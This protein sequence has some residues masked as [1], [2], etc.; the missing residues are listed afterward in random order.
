MCC[1]KLRMPGTMRCIGR[2]LLSVVGVG[3]SHGSKGASAYILPAA[4]HVP[5]GAVTRI[6][7]KDPGIR[8]GRT[9]G[10]S[11]DGTA[12]PQRCC[13]TPGSANGLQRLDM[14]GRRARSS[15]ALLFVRPGLGSLGRSDDTGGAIC[16]QA[17]NSSGKQ[18]HV[19]PI[20]VTSS[21]R[22][23]PFR[24]RYQGGRLGK[25]DMTL[26][27]WI[28][29]QDQ[30]GI[31]TSGD[32][33]MHAIRTCVGIATLCA[34]LGTFAQPLYTLHDLGTLGGAESRATGIS[35]EGS[36]T[37]WSSNRQGE[38]VGLSS[39][40]GPWRTRRASTTW[41]RSVPPLTTRLASLGQFCCTSRHHPFLNP[42]A[43]CSR[44]S[45]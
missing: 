16:L 18:N 28:G 8:G 24:G 13:R 31:R 25:C 35:T 19:P 3:T 45:E 33:S 20:G 36:V 1:A 27:E 38:L 42:L 11:K 40:V 4:S 26:R 22:P 39:T 41:G 7:I 15:P 17:S 44:F 6:E 5:R 12:A 21:L 9:S 2:S 32:T 23:S 14:L 34:S 10:I 29:R 43:P 30:F 37:G